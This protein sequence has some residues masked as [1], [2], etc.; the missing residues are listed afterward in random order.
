MRI[1]YTIVLFVGLFIGACQSDTKPKEAATTTPPSP[2]YER[3][4]TWTD[5]DMEFQQSYCLQIM[6]N[7]QDLDKENYCKCFLDK[8]KFYYEPVDVLHAYRQERDFSQECMELHF[9]GEVEE[10]Q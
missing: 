1:F 7:I 9:S 5:K 4:T 8:V 6:A 3:K 10:E 2:K